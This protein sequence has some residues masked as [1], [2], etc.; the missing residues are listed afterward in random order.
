[1]AMNPRL[2]RP[3]AS[4]DATA[5]AYIAAVEKADGQTLESG[6][7]KAISDFV[8]GCKLDG[9]WTAIQSSCILMGARTLT[10]ALTSLSGT[11]PTNVNF[12]SGDYDRKTGL[13]G[14]GSTKYLNSNRNNNAD[15]QNRKHVALYA[16]ALPSLE[17]TLLGA[18]PNTG[19]GRTDLEFSSITTSFRFYCNSVNTSVSRSSPT[20]GFFGAARASSTAITSRMNGSTETASVNSQTPYDGNVFVFCRNLNGSPN[21]YAAARIAFYSIGD[22]LTLA[23]L[24]SRVSA[25]Y[26]AIGAAI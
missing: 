18:L 19:S 7:R 15:E 10:G 23:T 3:R 5:L 26:T 9:I 25:L 21:Q 2:L 17:G 1:M 12:V 16:S 6:V 20:A 11:A 4:G 13:L 8:V 14:N 22:S 24:D